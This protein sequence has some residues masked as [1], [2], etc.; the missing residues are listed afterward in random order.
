MTHFIYRCPSCGERSPDGD[1]SP[2]RCRKG[3][4]WRVA[5]D[6]SGAILFTPKAMWAEY[7]AG[8]LRPRSGLF[9][10]P[11]REQKAWLERHPD[12]GPTGG[13]CHV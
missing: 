6:G 11:L 2:G 1:C 5:L 10:M 8:T 13:P 3:T 9:D 4:I 7:Q 12:L